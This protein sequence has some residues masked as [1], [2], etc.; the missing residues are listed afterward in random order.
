M[1]E[2]LS[3]FVCRL[4]KPFH[5]WLKLSRSEGYVNDCFIVFVVPALVALRSLKNVGDAYQTLHEIT[6]YCTRYSCLIKSANTN[7]SNPYD[8]PA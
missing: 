1:E 6:T 5:E 4:D 7:P 2:G 3:S 8:P